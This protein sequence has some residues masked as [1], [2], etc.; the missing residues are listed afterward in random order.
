MASGTGYELC[1]DVCMQPGHA[2]VNAIRTAGKAA[3]GG[4]LYLEGHTYA[5]DDC[6]A[7]ASAAGIARVVVGQPPGTA[8]DGPRYK[9]IGNSWAVP[10]VRWI[11]ARI[12][13]ELNGG[14]P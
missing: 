7:T 4:V 8:A 11:G 14:R 2:E 3:A 5:C 12:A 9:A 10:V 13:H 1:R 6:K